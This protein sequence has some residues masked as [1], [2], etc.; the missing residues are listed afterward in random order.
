MGVFDFFTGGDKPAPLT[1]PAALVKMQ[2]NYS[3]YNISSPYGSSFYSTDRDGRKRLN[4]QET[5]YQ[6][7]MRA[8]REE[9]AATFFESLAG[10]DDRFAADAERIGDL[11]FERGLKRLQPVLDKARRRTEVDLFN[12]GNPMGSEGRALTMNELQANESDLYTNLAG[13]SELAARDEQERL[14]RLSNDEALSFYGNEVSGIDPSFFNN[15]Q[16]IDAAG[17]FSGQE[18][19]QQSRRKYLTQKNINTGNKFAGLASSVFGAF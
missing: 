9:G 17:I 1:D 2:D 5:D 14:R 11:T 3:R 18:Q 13:Q 12:S 4:I 8:K 6:K 19:A 15:V 7:Q 16:D 10:G